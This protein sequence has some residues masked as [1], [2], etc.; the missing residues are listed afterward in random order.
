MELEK[1]ITL[2][3]PF[4]G[5]KC[6]IDVYLLGHFQDLKETKQTAIS[7]EIH[8]NVIYFTFNKSNLVIGALRSFVGR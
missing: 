3:P 4:G 8:G 5:A 1:I 2:S 6:R 7:T